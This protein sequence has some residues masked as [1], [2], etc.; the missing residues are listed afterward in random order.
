MSKYTLTLLD[1]TGIQD[2]IFNSNRLQENIGASEIVYRATT[3]WV[4]KALEETVGTAHNI[5]NRES[6]DWTFDEGKNIESNENLKAEVI[7]AAGGNVIILFR[8]ATA[9]RE[10]VN[11]I[12][13]RVLQDAPGLNLLAQHNDQFEFGTS[14][15]NLPS[16][17]NTLREVKMKEHKL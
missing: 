11:K 3:L 8:D 2:Y 12:T 4:F 5:L 10:F 13:W 15:A 14:P 16:A 6:L 17:L 1:T 9:S 7:Q